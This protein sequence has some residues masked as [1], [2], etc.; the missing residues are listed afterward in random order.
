[1]MMNA[2]YLIKDAGYRLGYIL[3]F[4]PHA[5]KAARKLGK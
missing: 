4:K 1:M 5:W 2:Y 3:N